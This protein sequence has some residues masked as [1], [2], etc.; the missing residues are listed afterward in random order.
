MYIFLHTDKKKCCKV[1]KYQSFAAEIGGETG[2]RISIAPLYLIIWATILLA[3]SNESRFSEVLPIVLAL[4]YTFPFIS[5]RVQSTVFFVLF[6]FFCILV[7]VALHE[8]NLI[9]NP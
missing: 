3:C 6:D 4:T 1:D 8:I 2:M 9:N 7:D 5:L